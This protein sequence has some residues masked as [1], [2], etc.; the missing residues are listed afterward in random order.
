MEHSDGMNDT[1]HQ[2]QFNS[3]YTVPLSLPNRIDI[4]DASP[5]L[6]KPDVS[7]DARI[8]GITTATVATATAVAAVSIVLVSTSPNVLSMLL[9]LSPSIS[10]PKQ[11]TV[12]YPLLLLSASA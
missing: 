6:V 9:P 4:A 10:F 1:F 3:S 5:H 12:T 2:T 8:T 7:I 11:W